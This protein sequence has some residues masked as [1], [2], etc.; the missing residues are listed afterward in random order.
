[1]AKLDTNPLTLIV[2]ESLDPRV[3]KKLEAQQQAEVMTH[4]EFALS[5]E[6]A[7]DLANVE[8]PK[9]E[10]QPNPPAAPATT[11][12]PVEN[13]PAATPAPEAPAADT[14]T[15]PAAPATPPAQPAAPPATTPAPAPAAAEPVPTPAPAP[16][17]GA[18]P[19]PAA[20]GAAPAA[21]PAGGGEDDDL[22]TAFESYGHDLDFL[23]HVLGVKK[24]AMESQQQD[25][26]I[27]NENTK[28]YIHV[29]AGENGIDRR[30][31][32]AIQ[33]I[34]DPNN[35]IAVIEEDGVDNVEDLARLRSYAKT[36]EGRGAR[37]F[38]NVDDSI[39]YLNDVYNEMTG[40][41]E[42]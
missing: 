38:N 28:S 21:A 25:E 24:P 29:K 8:K 14:T 33:Q 36:L 9:D 12:P 42:S 18:Q 4:K 39:D 30:T 11:P 3:R 34:Q 17:A 41:T 37:V 23:A 2:S 35:V 16:Q 26:D 15:P 22:S 1:M 20:S 19:A 10:P 7:E 27:A 13:T 6:N 32:L 5:V 31:S 40:K